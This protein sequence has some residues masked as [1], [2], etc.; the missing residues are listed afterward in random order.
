MRAGFDQCVLYACVKFRFYCYHFMTMTLSLGGFISK[1]GL[2]DMKS[3]GISH[4][5]L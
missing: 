2:I 1:M 3:D 4:G 5:T